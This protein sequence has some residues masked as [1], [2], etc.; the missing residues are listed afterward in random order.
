MERKSGRRRDVDLFNFSFLDILACV[1]G[2]L[3]FILTIVVVSGGGSKT[4]QAARD[5]TAADRRLQDEQFAAKLASERRATLE[6]MLNR[7]ASDALDPAGAARTVKSETELLH[8]EADAMSAAKL[9]A[10]QDLAAMRTEV[11]KIEHAAGIDPAVVAAEAESQQ[12]TAES[13]RLHAQAAQI[14]QGK[15]KDTD[16]AYYVPHL[17]ETDRFPVWLEV[18][19]NRV[20]SVQ[21]DGY[22]QIPQLDGGVQFRRRASAVGIRVGDGTNPFA[23]DLLTR[24]DPGSVVL[25]IAV[26]PDGFAAFRQLREQAWKRGY[27]VNWIPLGQEEPL[28]LISTHHAFEQ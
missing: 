18:V 10:E 1:I 16:I 15:V 6:T 25:S 12:L 27:S 9:R 4:A 17:R 23:F 19:G 20:W 8:H 3:I 5:V 7:R 21:S 24:L 22:L 2:L 14:H 13:E 11:D 26:R 28:V